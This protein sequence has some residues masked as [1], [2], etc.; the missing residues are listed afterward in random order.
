MKT[1]PMKHQVE[2]ERLLLAAPEFFALGAEQG[3]GKTWML[4]NDAEHQFNAGRINGLFV[5]APKGVH[6][7]WVRREIPSHMSVPNRARYWLSGSGVKHKRKMEQVFYAEPGELAVLTMNVD[8]VNT[9]AG[10]ETAER[11]LKRYNAMFVIDE[12]QRIKTPTAKRTKAIIELSKLAVS[13]RI[14]SGTLVANSPLD[15]FSQYEFLQPGL[16]GTRSFRAFT[17]EYAELLPP[18]NP[19]VQTIRQRS[20]ARG[21]PQVVAKNPDGRPKFRNLGKL[22]NIISPH[23]YRVLK[24]DCLD[25]PE[26][27]YTTQYFE[28]SAAQRR[29]YERVKSELRYERDDGEIDTFT[30]LT[31]INKLRQITSGFIMVDGEATSLR[32]AG[33]RLSALKEIVADNDGQLIIWASFREEI[34]QI[35]SMLVD[36]E[37]P[38]VT[39]YGDTSDADR[40]AAIDDFQSGAAR[41]FIG[42]PAAAGTG[43][44]LTA[45]STVV[46]YSCS[47]SLEQRLQSEDRAH[48]IGVKHNV[49]YIDLAARDTI[50]EQIAN[51]LQ[52]KKGVAAEVLDG[53]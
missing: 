34:R 20:R 4:L 52:S 35:Y 18:D 41:V 5:I 8:A 29:V 12:S 47:Y 21:T 40:E 11:F 30:A 13:R 19:L 26:K 6:V 31:L 7:N 27:I 10:K 16:L 14:A 15:L 53:R 43:L 25:L 22:H 49:V 44:T 48:R 33:P 28:L 38:T 46:Y 50:D 1:T 9:K 24:E 37:I 42:H 39:Y 45:A 17:A 36:M 51:A 3:T 23:T 32:E 2:G